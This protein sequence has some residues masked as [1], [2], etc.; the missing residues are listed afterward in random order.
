[1]KNKN[2]IILLIVVLII[3]VLVLIYFLYN[4]ITGKFEFNNFNSV[5]QGENL[6]CIIEESYDI[7]E[8]E[9]LKIKSN[10][11]DIKLKNSEDSALKCEIYG[12]DVEDV[13]IK[14]N[15]KELNITY[16]QKG[17][18]LFGNNYKREIIIFIPNE[19]AGNINIDSDCGDIDVSNL[20]KASL[21]IK[22]DCGDTEIDDIK[23]V[24][25]D[26]AL[27]DIKINTINNKCKIESDC[28]DIKIQDAQIKENSS[29]KSDL[30]DVKIEKIND[31][32]VDA[33]TDLGEVEIENNN[34]KSEIILEIECDC[35]DVKIDC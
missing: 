27:G 16:S 19:F 7:E 14:T 1:M 5:F 29:I 22:Q 28:G 3:V 35:G 13:E 25:V 12:K 30:G 17:I 24:S 26:S 10:L 18:N 31:I 34:R 9:N 20:K 11:G 32:Y 21:D 33:E 4:S 15:N 6:N 23:N 8:I 2:A